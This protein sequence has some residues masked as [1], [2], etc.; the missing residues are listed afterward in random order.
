MNVGTF[1]ALRGPSM[2]YSSTGFYTKLGK[3]KFKKIMPVALYFKFYRRIFF[4][5][6]GYA[7][8]FLKLRQKLCFRLLLYPLR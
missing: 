7:K 6:V 4:S 8:I 1:E 2:R 3:K 5:A